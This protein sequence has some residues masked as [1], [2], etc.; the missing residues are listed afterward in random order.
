MLL[1]RH[2]DGILKSTAKEGRALVLGSGVEAGGNSLGAQDLQPGSSSW[3]TEATLRNLSSAPSKHVASPYA[4]CTP[5]KL[6][7]KEPG[8][9]GRAEMGWASRP[10]LSRPVGRPR[11]KE[12]PRGCSAHVAPSIDGKVSPRC[13]LQLRTIRLFPQGTE[14]V[15]WGAAPFSPTSPCNSAL[16]GHTAPSSQVT[17]APNAG[18]PVLRPPWQIPSPEDPGLPRPPLRLSVQLSRPPGP[19]PQP[20]H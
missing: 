9:Q 2:G 6:L 3:G 12:R 20:Q 17:E 1:E 18:R 5:R 16:T 11:C 4:N 7:L 10:G 13:A 15:T 19:R 8:G 14:P